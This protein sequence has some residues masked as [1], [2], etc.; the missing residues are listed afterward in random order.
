MRN[1]VVTLGALTDDDNGICLSQ[2]A[3]GAV[4]LTLNGVLATNGVAYFTY[5]QKV[6]VTSAGNDSARTFTITGLDPDGTQITE[7]LTGANVGAANTTAYFKTVSSIVTSAATAAAVIVGIIAANG[8]VSKSI[9]VNRQQPNFKFSTW[10]DVISGTLT[11]SAQYAYQDPEGDYT[12]SFSTD[13]VWIAPTALSA[14]TADANLLIEEVVQCMR[15]L[16]SAYTSGS[17][18]MTIAQTY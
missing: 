7:V 8:A 10:C 5:A 14:K 16:I 15:L 13:A 1:Q 9:R 11:Y 17:V 3:S 6:T 4:A 18:R 2:T 12:N